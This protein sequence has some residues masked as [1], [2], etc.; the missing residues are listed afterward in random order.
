MEALPTSIRAILFDLDGTLF[1]SERFYFE[2][3][4]DCLRERY[5]ATITSDEFAYF[6]T[7]LDD[8]LISHLIEHGR[9]IPEEAQDAARIRAGILDVAVARFDELIDSESARQGAALLHAF[10]QRVEVPFALV[11]CSESEYVTPFL[12]RYD[13]HDVF[14]L[15][16]TG[17]M[18][19]HKKPEPEIYEHALEHLGLD[20]SQVVAI[21]DAQRGI[22]AATSIGI[23]TIR[24]KAFLLNREPM[25]Q[26]IEVPDLKSALD[27][28]ERHL[29]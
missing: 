16:L 11:T 6:E 2:I 23:A 19:V 15:V 9:V 3:Y 28:I 27:L 22:V 13:L 5:G 24:P 21:E 20:A 1:D 10:A 12:D 25:P 17:E 14:D 29:I 18:V 7:V 26:A 4:R 8:A